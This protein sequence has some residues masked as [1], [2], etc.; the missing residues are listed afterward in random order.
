MKFKQEKLRATILACCPL[1]KTSHG[2][3]QS[4]SLKLSFFKDL[5]LKNALNYTYKLTLFS[6]WLL[7]CGA[8]NMDHEIIIL[9]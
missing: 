6:Q 1:E 3:V 7:E 5:P 8:K 2:Q 4:N 9:A